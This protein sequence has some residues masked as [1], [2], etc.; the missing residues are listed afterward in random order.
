MISFRIISRLFVATAMMIGAHL[1]AIV[2]IGDVGSKLNHTKFTITSTFVSDHIAAK[3]EHAKKAFI[4]TVGHSLDKRDINSQDFAEHLF[5]NYGIRKGGELLADRGLLPDKKDILK[6]VDVVP[7]GIIRDI[8][9]PVVEGTVEVATH[10]ETL[11]L[12]TMYVLQ[13]YV[14]PSLAKS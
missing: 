11:T 3:N 2:N 4:E 5:I 1:N 9:N 6:K 8:V 10:P 7:N 13:N 12:A 14:I